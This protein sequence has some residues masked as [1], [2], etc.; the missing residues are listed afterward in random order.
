MLLYMFFNVA[1][2]IFAMLQFLYF[3]V[4]FANGLRW[5]RGI[6]AL[7]GMGNSGGTKRGGGRGTVGELGASGD[8][9]VVAGPSL[10]F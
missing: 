7:W 2:Y 5:G 3:D 10:Y 6:E 9:G 1:L 8:G 4:A